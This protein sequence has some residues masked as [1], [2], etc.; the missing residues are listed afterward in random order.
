MAR[1]KASNLGVDRDATGGMAKFEWE[2][3]H[4]G[5]TNPE[6]IFSSNLADITGD[7]EVDCD[8][9]WCEKT[10]TVECEGGAPLF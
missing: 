6:F 3:P 7:F 2:C 1:V 4:C 10:V 9:D 8:C 5:Q